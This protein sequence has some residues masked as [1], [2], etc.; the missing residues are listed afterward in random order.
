LKRDERA[1]DTVFGA[2]IL[3]LVCMMCSGI[4]LSIDSAGPDEKIDSEELESQFDCILSSTIG[5]SSSD[6]G[7]SP[8]RSMAIS[9][10]LVEMPADAVALQSSGL[11]GSAVA[12]ISTVVDFY[13]ARCTGWLLR[14]TW[15][16]NSTK[17]IASRNQA[18]V[19]GSDTYVLER[20]VPDVEY[21]SR[22][23]QLLLAV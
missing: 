14:L 12:G 3:V 13:M 23:I 2:I 5:L 7:N 9:A 4:L 8:R 17:E 11:E 18:A 10:Y 15:D 1:L 21:G 19:V 22:K 16:D 20:S 6:Q